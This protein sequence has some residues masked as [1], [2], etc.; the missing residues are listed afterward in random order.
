[1]YMALRPVGRPIGTEGEEGEVLW[2]EMT[3][4]VV[5]LSE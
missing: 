3:P 4:T 1:M 5:S 2:L